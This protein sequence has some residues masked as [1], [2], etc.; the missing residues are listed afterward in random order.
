MLRRI[1]VFALLLAA[2]AFAA[3]GGEQAEQQESEAAAEEAQA[4]MTPEQ[5][6]NAA[7][8]LYAHAMQEVVDLLEGQPEAEEVTPK[9]EELKESYV[10]KLVELGHKREALDESGRS[11][12]N[13]TTMAF[14]G[15]I[16][17]DLYEAYRAAQRNYAGSETGNLIASFNTITQYMN[18]DLLKKQEPAEAERLG[19]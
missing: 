7:G 13:R 4:E 16:S 9:L 6:G 15:N 10:Q 14:L 11:V 18:F 8:R 19:L 12:V 1:G 3:C 5:I 2:I 17:P